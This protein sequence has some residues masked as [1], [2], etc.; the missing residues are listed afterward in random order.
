[1]DAIKFIIDRA[2]KAKIPAGIH[3]GAAFVG[4]RDDRAGLSARYARQ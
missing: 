2:K 4:A 3:C 1:M